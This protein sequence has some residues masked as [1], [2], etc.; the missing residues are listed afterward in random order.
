MGAAGALEAVFVVD[1]VL[2][3]VL[4]HVS[5]RFLPDEAPVAPEPDAP[6]GLWRAVRADRSRGPATESVGP[7]ALIVMPQ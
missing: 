3:L 2:T 1:G 6:A 7:T 5:S 4:R